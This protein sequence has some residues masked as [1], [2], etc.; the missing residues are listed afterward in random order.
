MRSCFRNKIGKQ[1]SSFCKIG[2]INPLLRNVVNVKWSEHF[3]VCIVDFEQV[4]AG[5]E[6]VIKN[7]PMLK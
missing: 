3:G 1:V 4:N 6:I 2:T 5:C 7:Q